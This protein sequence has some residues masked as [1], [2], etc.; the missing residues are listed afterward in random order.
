MRN[1][2]NALR[3]VKKADVPSSTVAKVDDMLRN[4]EHRKGE[5]YMK[6]R[7]KRSAVVAA[8]IVAM[9]LV[10]TTALA[11]TNSF[12][13]L[14][15]FDSRNNSGDVLPNASGIVQSD[16]PQNVGLSDMAIFAVRDAIFDGSD[17]YIAFT[18]TPK[19]DDTLLIPAWDYSLDDPIAVLGSLFNGE[20]GTIAEYATANKLKIAMASIG[21]LDGGWSC[22]IESD[23]T[24]VIFVN[25]Q[26]SGSDTEA[27][28]LELPCFLIPVPISEETQSNQPVATLSFTLNNTRHFEIASLSQV[29]EFIDIGVRIDNITL[30]AS[31]VSVNVKVEYT[32]IDQAKFDTLDGG[33]MFEFL[34]DD[35]ENLPF[36]P[37]QRLPDGPG[38]GEV[39]QL[40]D[41]NTRFEQTWS[42][43]AME[44]LP[45][46]LIVRGFNFMDKTRYETHVID[47]NN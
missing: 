12:G 46:Y 14:D 24:L 33:L 27:L 5:K 45:S 21:G 32:V 3:N 36:G 13:I 26:H 44:D 2:E 22:Q 19:E 1:I 15:Y 11:L 30:S 37:E 25:S 43:A 34:C 7:Y 40:D 35:Y 18:V 31:E 29:V 38:N 42:L 41:T 4:L 10:T 16:V 47:T 23:R 6:P 39:T 28:N 8:A 17:I 20:T 9:L